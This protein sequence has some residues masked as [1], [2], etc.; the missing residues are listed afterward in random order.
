MPA[1]ANITLNKDTSGSPVTITVVPISAPSDKSALWRSAEFPELSRTSLVYS[2]RSADPATGLVKHSFRV[3]FPTLKSVVS[4]PGGPF[5][6]AP[7]VDYVTVGELTIWA[8]PRSTATERMAP[9]G[10][11][12]NSTSSVRSAIESIVNGYPFY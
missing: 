6:P 2:G 12:L 9:M 5:E 4:D 8:H 11:F 10:A 3:T 7:V 1:I